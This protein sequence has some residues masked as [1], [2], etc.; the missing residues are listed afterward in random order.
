MEILFEVLKKF[1][2]LWIL[3]IAAGVL[4]IFKP[5]I[6]GYFGE[7]SVVLILSDFMDL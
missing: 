6:K 5:K 4:E 1:W 7:K 3:V 2:Y